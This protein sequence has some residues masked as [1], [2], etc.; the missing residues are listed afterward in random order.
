MSCQPSPPEPEMMMVN[1][2]E[3]EVSM[4]I[5]V[6]F[7]NPSGVVEAQMGNSSTSTSM[8]PTAPLNDIVNNDNVPSTSGGSTSTSSSS[9]V[10]VKSV[11]PSANSNP[12]TSSISN[13]VKNEDIRRGKEVLGSNNVMPLDDDDDE[14]EED[15]RSELQ[16]MTDTLFRGCPPEWH[17]TL[18]NDIR[19]QEGMRQNSNPEPSPGFLSLFP[20]K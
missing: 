18:L 20:R 11:S 1:N 3:A 8:E 12:S 6:E 9:A 2:I 16:S 13:T 19:R 7:E 5:D 15:L 17:D 10:S 4:E 14:N